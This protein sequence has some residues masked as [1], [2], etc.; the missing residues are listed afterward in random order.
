VYIYQK[1]WKI[2]KVGFWQLLQ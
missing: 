1:L 2:M